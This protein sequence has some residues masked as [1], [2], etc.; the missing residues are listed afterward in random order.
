MVG[1]ENS[2]VRLIVATI[3]YILV[4]VVIPVAGCLFRSCR[5]H[6]YVAIQLFATNRMLGAEAILLPNLQ[7]QNLLPLS[8]AG[9][10]I[11]P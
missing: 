9:M 10:L 8:I 2:H 5:L 11:N 4:T 3:N 1:I 7:E 6:K